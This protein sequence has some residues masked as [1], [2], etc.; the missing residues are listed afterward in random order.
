VAAVAA[1]VAD[2]GSYAEFMP[3][4]RSSELWVDETG[5]RLNEQRLDLPFPLEDR[6]YTVR[7][8]ESQ[9]D[10]HTWRMEWSYVP[11]SGN[12]ADTRGSWLV[13]RRGEGSLITYLVHTDPGTRT[14]RWAVNLASKRSIPRMLD[15]VRRRVLEYGANTSMP[16][17]PAVK[18]R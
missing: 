15:A 5:A 7:L 13:E 14:P 9:V 4:V 11:G 8:R 16:P 6:R 17:R 1:V 10:E 12:V 3:R 2:A 18:E